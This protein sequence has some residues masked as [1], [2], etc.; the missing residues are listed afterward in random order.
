MSQGG[1]Q[2]SPG[3]GKVRSRFPVHPDL[4]LT[5]AP[6][7]DASTPCQQRSGSS[8]LRPVTIHQLLNAEQAFA[9]AEFYID[10]AEVK[11]VSERAPGP[12]GSGP[13]LG[14]LAIRLLVCSRRNGRSLTHASP[15]P[16]HA[17]RVHPQHQLDPDAAQ[18]ARRGR[19]GCAL[20]SSCAL[21]L[22]SP[23][24]DHKTH[25]QVR[26]TRGAGRTRLRMTAATR[27][28]TS[29]ASAPRLALSLAV[30]A[31]RSPVARSPDLREQD[32]Y[33][34]AHHRPA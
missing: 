16:G 14:W 22:G 25:S 1:S 3:G 19:H 29:S 6:C 28:R 11:D 27:T 30:D 10:G 23:Q 31:R 24:A 15:K 33:V 17:R 26:L 18:H 8:A 32:Q 5:L 12:P 4:E 9:E 13:F 2:S 20:S 34:R 21:P 7:L